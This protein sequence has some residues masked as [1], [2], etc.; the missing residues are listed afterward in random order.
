VCHPYAPHLYWQ[1]HRAVKK[2][3]HLPFREYLRS[4]LGLVEKLIHSLALPVDLQSLSP[5][6]LNDLL[7]FAVNRYWETSGLFGAV[8]SCAPT[9]EQIK[10]IG[11]SEVACLIDFGVDTDL[12][13]DSLPLLQKVMHPKP[14][15]I[16][17]ENLFHQPII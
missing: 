12:V 17:T 3:I 15:K 4:S 2:L 9:V 11:V 14:P 10:N 7:D 8:E 16:G 6:D 13:L 1:R 5:Q